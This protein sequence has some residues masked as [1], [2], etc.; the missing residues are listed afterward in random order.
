[1]FSLQNFI[2]EKVKC[3]PALFNIVHLNAQSLNDSSHYEEFCLTF[4]NSKVNAIA[5]SETFFKPNSRTELPGYNVYRND[6][7]GK[8]GGGVAL[9]VQNNIEVNVLSSSPSEYDHKPE[10]LIVDM[11]LQSEKVLFACVYRPPK[12][13]F[14]ETFI[15][16]LCTFIPMYKYVVLCGDV[17]AKFG[18]G[19]GETNNIVTLLNSCNVTCIPYGNTFHTATCDSALDIIA[20]NCD[21]LVIDFAKTPAAGFSGHDLLFACINLSSPR[22]ERKTIKYRDYKNLDENK[23]KE[24]ADKIDWQEV[25][26]CDNVDG[27]VEIFNNTVLNLFDN[28]VPI[29][30]VKVKYKYNPWINEGISVLIHQRDRAR[31]KY[32]RTKAQTDY[33]AFKQ[34]RNKCKQEMRNAKLRYCHTAFNSSITSKQ[35]WTNIKT[36]GIGKKKSDKVCNLSPDELNKYYLSVASVSNKQLV[37]EC[38]EEYSLKKAVGNEK[39]HFKNVEPKDII[40]AVTSINSKAEGVDKVSVCMIKLCIVYL[41][42]VICHIF[43]F[44]LMYGTFPQLWKKSLVLPIPKKQNPSELKDYRP[45][46]IICVMAK[47]FEKI[48]HQQVSEYL[49]QFNII[50]H[51]QSGFLKGNSTTTALIQVTDDIREAIDQRFLTLLILFDFSKAFD[52]VQHDL[53]LAKLKILGFSEHAISWFRSYL[54]S[55]LQQVYID[56]TLFSD[57][58]VIETGVPQGSVLG[59]LLYLL[60]VND[61][62]NIFIHGKVRLYADD[63]QLYIKFKNGNHNEAVRNAESEI[64]RLRRYAAQHNLSLNASK[65]QPIILGSRRFLNMIDKKSLSSINIDGEVVPYCNTVVN[66]GVVM[67]P[68]LTWGPHVDHVCKKVFS[69]IAQLRRDAYYLPLAVKKQ[70]IC[71]LVFPHLDYGSVVMTDMNVTHKIKL[72]RLQNACV[73]YIYNLPKDSEISTYYRELSWLKVEDKRTLHTSLVLWNILRNKKPHHLFEKYV[74]RASINERVSRN[75]QHLLQ[76]PSHRTQKYAKSFFVNSCKIYNKLKLFGYINYS[77]CT[78][79]HKVKSLIMPL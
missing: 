69:I 52:R 58:S 53:L 18:S 73:R 31:K 47:V 6:R 72:Q 4:I 19:T 20:T 70:I 33:E 77:Y 38:I 29:K 59:P 63:L 28:I 16:D 50:N 24:A 76:L 79:K 7:I 78:Y 40:S 8:G 41:I 66:L 12:A 49:N 32:A 1:M 2:N 74:Q 51:C 64:Q 34:L 14:F 56:S 26:D 54:S 46:S 57:W 60:Y 65:T 36:L 43:D 44:S 11:K 17:N 62:S 35:M 3:H 25:Y 5:V 30:S 61:L 68:T 45:V 23:L 9:Y 71:S 48:V 39:F 13:G 15:E 37:E 42:P 27:K 21:E 10:Y 55:R 67:D 22:F 75:S